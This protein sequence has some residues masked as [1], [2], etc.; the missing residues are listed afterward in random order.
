MKT[1][2]LILT[3]SI[4][5]TSLLALEPMAKEPGWSG[6]VLMGTG[7]VK[8]KSNEVAGNRIIDVEDKTIN[9]YNSPSSESAAIPVINGNARYTFNQQKT[10]FFVGNSLEN[11]LRMDTNIA[12]G[13]RHSFKDIGIIGVRFLAS[14]TPT[15]VWE[16]PFLTGT[17]RQDT[18]RTSAGIGIKW[19]NIFDSNFEIDLRSRK[20]EF[21]D[22]RNGEALINNGLAGTDAGLGGGAMY[23]TDV[24][25]KVLERDADLN[26]IELLYTFK[27]NNSHMLIPSLKST[28]QDADGDARDYSRADIKLTHLYIDKKWM[29]ASNIHVGHSEYDDRN[30][31]FNKKQDTD[32]IGG[33]INI[34][35]KNIFS[36]D[37]WNLN[38]GFYAAEGD[39]D[40]D[41]YDTE[42]VM[43]TIGMAYRF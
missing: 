12:L 10:E 33:G 36:L 23:I 8:Y 5:S 31:I 26:S 3:T 11:F 18:E 25:Q 2:K 30:P 34:T 20:I 39:S 13:I 29:I 24:Q 35:Y 19:E 32:F 21:D 42:I 22:D 4:L 1:L 15:D 28:L 38:S 40:I 17:S 7:G 41:F 14:V 6:F 43:F 16:D 27:L 9:G 37:N